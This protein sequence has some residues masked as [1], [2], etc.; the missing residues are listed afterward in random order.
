MSSTGPAVE[1]EVDVPALQA[2]I[3]ELEEALGA[4]RRG[5]VDA[6][7]VGEPGAERIYALANA[8][9]P[10]KTIVDNMSEG[11]LTV[12][13]RRI[14]LFAN[15]RF[16]Q[17]TGRDPTEIVGRPISAF[18]D[19]ERSSDIDALLAVSPGEQFRS[20]LELATARGPLSISLS[21]S[22]IDIE[23][24][25]VRCLVATDLTSQKEAERALERTNV[26]LEKA[27]ATKDRFLARMSHELRTPLNAILG[28][29]NTM[30]MEL[31]GPLNPEQHRQLDTVQ[32]SG[33]HLLSIINDMLDVA[34]IESGKLDLQLVSVAC[35]PMLDEVAESLRFLTAGKDI[36]LT[37]DAPASDVV[38]N[39]N[40]RA[41][42]Q[43]LINLVANAIK[44]TDHG[45]VTLK[46][47]SFE[48]SDRS[49]V[50]ISVTDTG[51]GI[52]ADDQI[53]LFGAFEQVDAAQSRQLG[54]TGLGLYISQ[55]L[56]GL[57]GGRI[58]IESTLNVGST[59][60]IVLPGSAG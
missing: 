52:A 32:T 26:E 10:Y 40:R 8:E 43:V 51:I 16:A 30:L 36:D 5:G 39:T 13:A 46:L 58:E 55:K 1:G 2:Q 24:A 17:M 59:F 49:E 4:I 37:I 21:A 41:L 6:V 3:A 56:T 9:R 28:Y 38:V 50:R 57:I 15:H 19:P 60:T 35:Q 48:G 29:T 12:S 27:S 22:C 20:D 7:V 45:S 23:G 31:P 18:F 11:A 33:R 54:G 25:P 47:T 53:R 42:T 44:F 34:K 14:V